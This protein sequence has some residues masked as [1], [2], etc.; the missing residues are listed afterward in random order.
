[1]TLDANKDVLIAGGVPTTG[2]SYRNYKASLGNNSFLSA[3]SFETTR[4]IQIRL[5]RSKKTISLVSKEML[6]S[7]D[8]PSW[9]WY[10]SLRNLE[11]Q[12]INEECSPQ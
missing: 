6:S 11:P 8:H 5:S 7:V 1:M 10:G 12:A 9:Y 4:V 2:Q 3:A